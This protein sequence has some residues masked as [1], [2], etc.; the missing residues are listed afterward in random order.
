[1]RAS[2]LRALVWWCRVA[3]SARRE[4][5]EPPCVPPGCAALRGATSDGYAYADACSYPVLKRR[6]GTRLGEVET[7]REPAAFNFYK[8]PRYYPNT[9]IGRYLIY[10]LRQVSY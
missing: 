8:Q 6:W 5:K 2:L 10:L 7:P 3:E 1:M 9:H 4:G